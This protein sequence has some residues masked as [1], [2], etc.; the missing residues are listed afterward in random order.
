MSLTRKQKMSMRKNFDFYR[1]SDFAFDAKQ[2]GVHEPALIEG[3]L[4]G[5]HL[6]TGSTTA[7]CN[8]SKDDGLLF[9]V[10]TN[11]DQSKTVAGM[12]FLDKK[13]KLQTVCWP[14]ANNFK[15]TIEKQEYLV[16][17]ATCKKVV[18]LFKKARANDTGE[19]VLKEYLRDTFNPTGY[20][21][22]KNISYH[23]LDLD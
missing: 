6:E 18:A 2:N 20:C 10:S 15:D 8:F 13:N 19:A 23:A 9:A 1:V 5:D 14:S 11:K 4:Y 16:D 22:N 7:V 17:E 3:L 21:E 12:L